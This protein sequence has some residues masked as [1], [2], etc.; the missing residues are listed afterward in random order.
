MID[1]LF[2]TFLL[3]NFAKDIGALEDIKEAIVEEDDEDVQK[4]F[5]SPIIQAMFEFMEEKDNKEK[6][7]SCND[8]CCKDDMED[9]SRLAKALDIIR[10]CTGC[11]AVLGDNL[12]CHI[13]L[14]EDVDFKITAIN[15]ALCTIGYITKEWRI[16]AYDDTICFEFQ[17]ED[18]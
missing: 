8:S 5:E 1:D 11:S 14:D 13:A 18:I 3:L 6:S 12:R 9:Y 2:G 7:C 17:L 10:K 15:N 4:A 16:F